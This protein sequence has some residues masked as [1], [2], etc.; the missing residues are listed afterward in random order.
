MI[1]EFFEH[2]NSLLPADKADLLDYY[3]KKEIKITTKSNYLIFKLDLLIKIN[4]FKT[5][6]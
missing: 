5:K 3:L 2:N 6:V 4:V 1:K